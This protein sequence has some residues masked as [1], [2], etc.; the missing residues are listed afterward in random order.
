MADDA[1]IAFCT[2]AD[3]PTARKAATEIVEAQLAACANILPRV[4]SIY[5]WQ[6]KLEANDEVLAV[7]KLA[8][9]RYS[10]FETKLRS[11]HPYDVPEIIACKI[12]NGLPDYVRWVVENCAT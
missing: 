9:S 4:H 3:E 7:F 11:L 5:R 1:L 12:D 6:G 2:F 8:A 10:E